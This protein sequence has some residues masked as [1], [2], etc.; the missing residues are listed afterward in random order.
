MDRFIIWK[1]QSYITRQQRLGKWMEGRDVETE[2][3]V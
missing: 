1:S 3:N 2:S